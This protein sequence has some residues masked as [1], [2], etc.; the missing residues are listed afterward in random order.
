MTKLTNVSAFTLYVGAGDC[1]LPGDSLETEVT[2]EIA[3]LERDGF[4]TVE[5]PAAT[6][7]TPAPAAEETPAPVAEEAAPAADPAPVAEET[8]APVEAAPAET[9]AVGEPAPAADPVAEL[10]AEL[11]AEVPVADVTTE[12]VAPAVE[13]TPAPVAV[14]PALETPAPVLPE[15]AV[16]ADTVDLGV[17]TVGSLEV[18][19]ADPAVEPTVIDTTGANTIT[20]AT[21]ADIPV[22]AVPAGDGTV[23]VGTTGSNT[24]IVTVGDADPV[25][26]DV[27][28]SDTVTITGVSPDTTV[29]TDPA[30][31]GV[32]E[33]VTPEVVVAP[34]T[35]PVD[36]V[37]APAEVAADIANV[38]A[39]LEAIKAKLD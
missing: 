30:A 25:T 4:I 14:E 34:T 9:V 1:I 10:P 31:A 8:P 26:V 16:V 15:P 6:E 23:I 28:S 37:A 27:S 18:N 11:P 39:A 29:V 19:P 17:E 38:I 20:I 24:L 36:V 21:D 7:E 5:H 35:A 3:N 33:V 32:G 13:E 2:Q 12:P 22:T